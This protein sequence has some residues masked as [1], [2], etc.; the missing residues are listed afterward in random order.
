[1]TD[2]PHRW[3]KGMPSPNPH[4][5]PRNGRGLA[6][7]IKAGVDPGELVAF[8][9]GVLRDAAVPV[10]VRVQMWQALA[11]RGWTR[12]PAQLQIE[13]S[14]A[15]ALPA[16]WSAMSLGARAEYL[17]AVRVREIAIDLDEQVPDIPS[18]DAT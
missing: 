17:E 5:R 13:T 16:D 14:Q 6:E 15:P 11:D 7:A 9:L 10:S 4:G 12:P 3:A 2:K 18:N 1:M 8:A